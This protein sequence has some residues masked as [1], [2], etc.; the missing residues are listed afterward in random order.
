M[1][2]TSIGTG[3]EDLGAGRGRS[4]EGSPPHPRYFT[5]RPILHLCVPG[6]SLSPK[7]ATGEKGRVKKRTRLPGSVGRAR[8]GPEP[9]RVSLRGRSARGELRPRTGGRGGHPPPHARRSTRGAAV[10]SRGPG[11]KPRPRATVV[12]HVC[13]LSL[14]PCPPGVTSLTILIIGQERSWSVRRDGRFEG[15]RQTDPLRAVT[16]FQSPQRPRLGRKARNG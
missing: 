6:T 7:A 12:G 3:P 5:G 9:D 16:S 2:L 1:D 13:G 14:E 11:R 15:R 10:L 4:M 8:D